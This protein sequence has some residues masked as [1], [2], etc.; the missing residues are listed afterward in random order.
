MSKTTKRATTKATTKPVAS[1]TP[2]AYRVGRRTRLLARGTKN[3][4]FTAGRAIG[5][6]FKQL[7]AG[8][9]AA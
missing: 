2:V 1:K 6:F 9:K 3:G 5:G 4:A 7:A 8:W